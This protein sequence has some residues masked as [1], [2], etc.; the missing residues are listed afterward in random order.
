MRRIG[1]LGGS[2]HLGVHSAVVVL[3]LAGCTDPD[4]TA[5]SY[6]D[7]RV[8]ADGPTVEGIDVSK[9]QG[10][11]DWDAVAGDGIAF[12]FIRTSH[13]LGIL[14]EYYATN[15]SEA[16]RVGILR[17]TYQYFSPGDDAIA[18]ADLLL[19][20]MGPLEEGDLP[21][22]L[23]VEAA[24]GMSADQIVAAIHTWSDRVEAGLGVAPIIYTAKYFW[25][26]S[27]GAPD[28]FVDQPLWV[29]N[30]D[31]T[32]PLI[33]DPWARW[34]FWQ[35]TSSGSVAGIAGN[36]D[37]DVWNGTADDLTGFTWSPERPADDTIGS[38]GARPDDRGGGDDTGDIGGCSAGG[39]GGAGALALVLAVMLAARPG[40][41]RRR[42][43]DRGARSRAR[44]RARAA[45]GPRPTSR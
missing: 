37:R 8:C 3:L 19:D 40:T 1:I 34:D 31:V 18:Q 45:R 9:W 44:I 7:L 15:W 5:V 12:A 4:E 41:R 25:Q 10:A 14:D 22:V 33:A 42:S 35:Y 43:R 36:V 39:R 24:D 28:D 6:H 2:A 26:D 20:R 11:I 13:G 38:V 27:V 30:Y 29:A 17:G 23:D 16:R 32:C 21:P